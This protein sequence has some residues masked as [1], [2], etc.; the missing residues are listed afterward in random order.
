MGPAVG[1]GFEF[2]VA[3]LFFAKDDA[4]A[5]LANSRSPSGMTAKK[6]KA[7]AKATATATAT[8]TADPLRG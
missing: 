1:L 8:A 3:S 2:R 7:K 5:S 6:A 4:L